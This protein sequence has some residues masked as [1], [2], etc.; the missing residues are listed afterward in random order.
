MEWIQT[1]YEANLAHVEH[2]IIQNL[3]SR[4]ALI[5]RVGRKLKDCI[6][7]QTVTKEV[8]LQ[9]I[10][11]GIRELHTISLA[12][13]DICISNCYVDMSGRTP[14]VFLDDL[15]YIRPIDASPPPPPH[16]SRLPRGHVLP[17]TARELDLLQ[18]KTLE[19]E[20]MSV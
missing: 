5:T 8:A 7:D 11:L 6:V 10:T 12:H 16:N 20:I 1:V 2:G 17:L 9:H 14:V 3:G 15:E 4:V 19:I 13:C 18:L